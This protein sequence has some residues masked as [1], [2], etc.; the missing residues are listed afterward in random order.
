M[1]Y[2]VGAVAYS[3]NH[4]V[5]GPAVRPLLPLSAW[6]EVAGA[7][8]V[9]APGPADT[10]GA[11][12]DMTKLLPRLGASLSA[13]SRIRPPSTP[14]ADPPTPSDAPPSVAPLGRRAAAAS[15]TRRAGR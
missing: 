6:P 13:P 7:L 14:T 8:L 10:N 1:L 3:P 2:S 5:D 15:G 12:A 9:T 4:A 11:R